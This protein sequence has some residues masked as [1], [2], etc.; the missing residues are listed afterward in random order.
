[1]KKSSNYICVE[2]SEFFETICRKSEFQYL[3][4]EVLRIEVSLEGGNE[5]PDFLYVNDC[6]PMISTKLRQLFEKEKIDNLYYKKI[7]L[8]VEDFAIEEEYWL[9]LPPRIDC[10]D[11]E[12]I[13]KD[14]GIAIEINIIPERVGNYK[15]FKMVNIGNSD[16]VITRELKEVIEVGTFT[17]IKIQ[18]IGGNT[19]E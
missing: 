17:G 16:I 9:A 3:D 14:L 13:D 19:N 12:C 18:K 7:I 6:V 5:F 10:V 8:S 15:I 4:K 2:V 1:M 11:P